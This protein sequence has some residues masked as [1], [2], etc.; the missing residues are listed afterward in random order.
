MGQ[1]MFTDTV[2]IEPIAIRWISVTH[3]KGRVCTDFDNE[4]LHSDF[5][6]KV[7]HHAPRTERHPMRDEPLCL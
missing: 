1:R 7:R 3:V 4:S 6:P 5:A 2:I